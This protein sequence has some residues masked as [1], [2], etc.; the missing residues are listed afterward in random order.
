MTQT[1]IYEVNCDLCGGLVDTQKF[2]LVPQVTQNQLPNLEKSDYVK[3]GNRHLD[4]CK[5]CRIPLE[6]EL[7]KVI[8]DKRKDGTLKGYRDDR[9][10]N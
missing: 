4:I 2:H 6:L 3:L 9:H 7:I 10:T 5:S 8:E 1:V